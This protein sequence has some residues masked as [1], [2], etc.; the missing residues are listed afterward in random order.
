MLAQPFIE[1]A[2]EHGI[3]HKH[4]KGRLDI[5]LFYEQEQLMYEIEDN[6]IGIE[7][8]MKLKNKLKSSYQS[9]AT[10]IT[11]ERMSILGEQHK[12]GQD[13]EITDKKQMAGNESGVKVR[14]SIPFKQD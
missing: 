1:N 4:G 12:S 9:L 2:I 8:A 5:R 3:Y 11:R 10:I 7:E 6:G 14:F 13:I